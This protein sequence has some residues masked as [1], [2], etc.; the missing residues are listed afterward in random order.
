MNYD[1]ARRRFKRFH[2]REPRANEVGVVKL[3]APET[4][5]TVGELVGVIYKAAGDGQQYIHRFAKDARPVLTVSADGKQIYALAGAYR[6]T[7]RGF[8]DRK[9]RK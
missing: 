4:V 7:E 6:F 2:D 8:V 1:D 5:L 3:S 9:R